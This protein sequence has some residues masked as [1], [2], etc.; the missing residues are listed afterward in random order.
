L[1]DS[2]PLVALLSE[3]DQYHGI[4]FAAADGLKGK[5]Y[6]SW[7]VITEAAHLLKREADAVQRLLAWI[8]TSELLI[9]PLTID[10]TD[11]I[12]RILHRY[13]DQNFDFADATLMH[14]AERDGIHTVFTID[15]RHFAIY[16]TKGRKQLEIVPAA[17]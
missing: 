7:A 15:H 2:G 8:R 13:Q 11:D 5:F 16:R 14:L 12:S 4:C 17:S 10:D 6:I 1:I 9:Q 3:R